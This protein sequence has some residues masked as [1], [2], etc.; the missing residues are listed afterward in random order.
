MYIAFQ[1]APCMPS[2]TDSCARHAPVHIK[3]PAATDYVHATQQVA[4]LRAALQRQGLPSV[5]P[6]RIFLGIDNNELCPVAGDA[7][8]VQTE[9]DGTAVTMALATVDMCDARCRG[10]SMLWSKVVAR[11]PALRTTSQKYRHDAVLCFVL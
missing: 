3:H 1:R 5:L 6:H 10:A 7:D 8:D 9:A 2:A 4:C 11:G